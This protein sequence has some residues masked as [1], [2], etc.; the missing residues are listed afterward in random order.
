MGKHARANCTTTFSGL[1]KKNF[2]VDETLR[3]RVSTQHTVTTSR[4]FTSSPQ[5]D[6]DSLLKRAMKVADPGKTDGEEQTRARRDVRVPSF[7]WDD[8]WVDAKA[9][10]HTLYTLP[11]PLFLIV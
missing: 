6:Q 8:Q 2:V 5:N 10:C 9:G 3:R 4:A 7:D 1:A 11:A